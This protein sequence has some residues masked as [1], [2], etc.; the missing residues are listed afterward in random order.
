MRF[1]TVLALLVALVGATGCDDEPT[2]DLLV[3]L[4]GALS[5]DLAWVLAGRDQCG[6]ADASVLAEGAEALVFIDRSG[7]APLQFIISVTGG[8]PSVGEYAGQV[9]FVTPEG[10]W[11]SDVGACTVI[12]SAR[13]HEDWSRIDFVTIE[14]VVDCPDGLQSVA[15]AMP[16]IT[17]STM[18]YSGHIQD[19]NLDF[20]NL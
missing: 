1:N 7:E 14:G 9:L 16:D 15:G 4:S 19:V 17:M 18:G 12:V 20:D 5:G 3:N 2:C 8:F 13:E 11:Q 6:F 10:L